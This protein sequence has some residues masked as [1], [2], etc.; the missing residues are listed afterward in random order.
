MYDLDWE[1]D[2]I[3]L[4]Q[5]TLLHAWWFVSSGDAK[6]PWYW[7]GSCL[8]LAITTGLNQ[9][10]TDTIPEP[11]TRRLW[12]RIWW[13]IVSRDRLM[14]LVTRKPARIKDDEINL[15]P[16]KFR[17][18][19]TKP[20][21]TENSLLLESPLVTES[22]GRVMLADMYIAQMDILL[23]GGRI[24]EHTY[25]LQIF[26]ASTWA[27]YYVPRP[28]KDLDMECCH[29]LKKE[30]DD[31]TRN[32]NPWCRLQCC[33]EEDFGE[34]GF[35][36]LR[37]NSASL[38]LLRLMALETLL[39]PLTFS[40]RCPGMLNESEDESTVEAR[41]D[42]TQ[43]AVDMTDL[44]STLRTDKLLEYVPPLSVGCIHTTLATFLV[45]FRLAGK[46][47]SDDPSHKF[48]E[49]VRS[50]VRLRDVW[51]ITK[52]TCALVKHGTANNQMWFARTLQM[53]APMARGDAAGHGQIDGHGLQ[54][55]TWTPTP[56]AGRENEFSS[57]VYSDL[58][59]WPDTTE[60]TTQPS[61][62]ASTYL[63]SIY[64]VPW[65]AADFEVLDLEACREIYMGHSDCFPA[66]ELTNQHIYG[67]ALGL[68][69]AIDDIANVS[70]Q[71]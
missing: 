53:L 46:R 22:I 1:N 63:S 23:I 25:A 2:R 67:E 5:A 40:G 24:I 29:Q 34:Q 69:P 12:R 4:I 19:D 39:R 37:I 3:V 35:G 48:H 20:Y 11:K 70:L 54:T 21:S 62:A 66:G 55:S 43:I 57:I 14:S 6:D 49:C 56:S 41:K 7:H 18:F 27:T 28:K 58:P 50:L 26:A 59:T 61:N 32:L 16:L 30:L 38:K 31:W 36:V 44:L 8:S 52:G 65:T 15:V 42:V 45:D 68:D 71:L 60:G 33:D 64:P 17:D 9:K 13:T 51:P 10:S 47:P